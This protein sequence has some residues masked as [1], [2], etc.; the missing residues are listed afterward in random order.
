VISKAKAVV[1]RIPGAVT[2]R[3]F[4]GRGEHAVTLR[5]A[6]RENILFTEFRRVP[7]QLAVL[8]G[9]VLDF[10]RAGSDGR[11]AADGPLRIVLFG[12]SIG[13]EPYSIAAAL[14]EQSPGLQLDMECFDIEP[15][16]V[17][18][19]R[20]A[21][22]AV[23][24]VTRMR[25]VTPEFIA[26]TFDRIDSAFVVKPAIASSVRCSV[27]NV[28]DRALVD[29]IAPADIVVAQ[30]FLFHL[31]R[32]DAARA[33]DHLNSLLKP[34]SALFI[35]GVDVDLRARLTSAAGLEP[36]DAEL[37]RIHGESSLERGYAWPRVYW[38]LE[39]F[40]ARRA[41]AVR[42]YATIFFRGKSASDSPG[43]ATSA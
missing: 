21:R 22:Y 43:D 17:A 5:F 36:C 40:N 15:S 11:A 42:R 9:P 41:D 33:F 16:V 18:R 20:A 30:N 37:E 25:H 29:S 39:P 6:R 24:E 10:L 4:V 7:T 26:H 32:T 19:A 35:D 8:T 3:R 23:D 14:H 38:G 1:R 13:A 28:L 2:L 12:S 31:S 27:G 34:R